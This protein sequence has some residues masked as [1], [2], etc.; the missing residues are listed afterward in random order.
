MVSVTFLATGSLDV[1]YGF[2]DGGLEINR[3]KLTERLFDGA[4][5]GN[6]DSY[7]FL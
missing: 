3:L 1:R 6:A 5:A 4:S 7:C 2:M